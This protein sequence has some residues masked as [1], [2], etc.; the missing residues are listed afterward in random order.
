MILVV[1]CEKQFKCNYDCLIP[2]I[3]CILNENLVVDSQITVKK[4]YMCVYYM[5]K[6]LIRITVMIDI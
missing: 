5:F 3:A 6:K 2:I 1:N 4:N